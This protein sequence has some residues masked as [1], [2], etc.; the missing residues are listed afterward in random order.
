MTRLGH[1]E[2]IGCVKFTTE[3]R[4]RIDNTT[5]YCRKCNTV[6]NLILFW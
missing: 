6:D 2:C 3:L 1:A 4:Q 5:N